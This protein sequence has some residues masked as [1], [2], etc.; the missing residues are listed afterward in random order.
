M[1]WTR[2]LRI[3]N[4][5]LDLTT[6]QIPS[7]GLGAA[8]RE[9]KG[10]QC[11]LCKTLHGSPLPL[12]SGS[13]P[14]AQPIA[15]PSIP[16]ALFLSLPPNPS[17]NPRPQRTSLRS[18]KMPD[19]DT[20]C[21]HQE[22]LPRQLHRPTPII[23]QGLLTCHLFHEAFPGRPGGGVPHVWAQALC[24]WHPPHLIIVGCLGLVG[25]HRKAVT[26]STSP[27]SSAPAHTPRL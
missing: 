11:S 6:A 25:D 20:R 15:S 16:L 9:L 1:S 3:S 18:Q 14:M 23:L 26:V 19:T 7:S 27:V 24:P 10:R 4:V 13:K 12:R 21:S 5:N 2:I 22:L 17:P 8:E